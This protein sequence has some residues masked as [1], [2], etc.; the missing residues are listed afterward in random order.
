MEDEDLF[1]S[2][3]LQVGAISDAVVYLTDHFMPFV[4]RDISV[5]TTH[6]VY[7]FGSR[8]SE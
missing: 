7:S 3:G 4:C 2:N 6:C 8:I 5:L 1:I